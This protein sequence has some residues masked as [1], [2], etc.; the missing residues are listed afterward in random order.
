MNYYFNKILKIAFE[1]AII[2]VTE[3]LKNDYLFLLTKIKSL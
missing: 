2:R 3:A 1:D